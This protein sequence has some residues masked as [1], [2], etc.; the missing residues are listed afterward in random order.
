MSFVRRAVRARF[1]SGL[2]GRAVLCGGLVLGPALALVW[3]P[4]CTEERLPPPRGRT[5][6]ATTGAG[7]EGGAQADAGSD[8]KPGPANVCECLAAYGGEGGR[9]GDC[10]NVHASRG[11]RCEA[12][13]AACDAEPGCRQI[14]LCL[15]DCVHN[16]ACQ[17][18]CVFPEDA[19]AAHRA[20]RQVL[21]CVCEAC[22]ATCAYVVPVECA[23]PEL[24]V[25]GSGA[26]SGDGG[27]GAASGGGAA[28]GGAAGGGGSAAGSGT[29]GTSG[30]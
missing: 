15:K 11:A 29:T 6:S 13:L 20:F 2:Y 28:G 22:G 12:H 25:G 30:G 21:A 3:L 1:G 8:G 10:L 19:G 18:R 24:G 7:S 26:A 23:E 5:A 16:K 9:C 4:G 17:T 14:S 27:S